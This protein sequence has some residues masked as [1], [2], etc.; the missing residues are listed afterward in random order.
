M[1]NLYLTALLLLASHASA[2]SLTDQLRDCAAIKQ[3]SERLACYDDLSGSLDKR[4]K[5]N[6]GREQTQ[7]SEE[8]PDS[9]SVKIATIQSGAYGKLIIT[10]DN[11]QVW[12]Q[13][14]SVRVH[15]DSGEQVLVERGAFGSF[16][17]KLES[18][19]RKIRVKRIK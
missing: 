18:G 4:A 14:D 10:L 17:M 3:D 12:R 5:Q 13:N 11:G 16:F 6:F 15:W 8:A 19:G 2:D 1:R 7:I 9:I